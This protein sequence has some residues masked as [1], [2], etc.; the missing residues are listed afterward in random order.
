[1][2]SRNWMW[3]TVAY[4]F[5]AL[6]MAVCMVA[7]G[8]PS[9]DNR[10]SHYR[11]ELVDLGPSSSLALPGQPL[12]SQ[13]T[14]AFGACGNPDCSVFHTFTWRNGVITDLGPGLSGGG[15]PLWISDSG[16]ILANA[17]NGVIDPL[18]GTPEERG[19]LFTNRHSLDIGTLDG[20]YESFG[21]AV[22]DSGRVV[23]V[24]SNFTPDPFSLFGYTTETRAILWRDGVMRDLG[25]LGGPDAM[26]LNVN[27]R[28]QVAGFSY[29][30]DTPN[31]TT[32]IPTL[33]PFLW[34]RGRVI[35][36]GTLGGT[37]GV[38]GNFSGNGGVDLNNRGQVAGTSDL[39]GDQTWHPFLWDRGI[40]TDLG[41]LGGSTGQATWINDAGEI[42]G[43]A[44]LP[45]DLVH[46]AFLWKNGVMTDLGNLGQTSFALSVNSKGQVVGD[47]YLDDVTSH[48]FLWE[49]GGPMVD[50]NTMIP[51]GSALQLIEAF[52][53]NDRGEIVGMGLP[54]G[55]GSEN[56]CGHAYVLIRNGDCDSDCEGRIAASQN[57][58]APA[59]SQA[60]IKRNSESPISP[61]ERLRHMRRTYHITGQPGVPRD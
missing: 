60:T 35:D 3:M 20:G 43:E 44:D 48:A 30:N 9:Q 59:Q 24:A 53:I 52:D 15:G 46:D 28:G 14:V 5:A 10:H 6:A 19:V 61:V 17:S 27:E 21:L 4:L 31:G 25:T 34:D 50:L 18:M 22:S 51:P 16:L 58:V 7:Q 11:Y 47:T 38:P 40:L 36:L 2:K 55:C 8:K 42:V 13:G 23:G 41:T 45:G 56:E 12:N 1:M 54:P 39:A 57:S 32:G 26:P 37:L 49:R 33:D 29:T